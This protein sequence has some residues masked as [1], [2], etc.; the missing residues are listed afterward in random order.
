MAIELM[1]GCAGEAHIS[2]EDWTVFNQATYGDTE[3]VFDWGNQFALNM[4]SANKGTIASGAGLVDG[5]RFWIKTPEEIT[6]ETGAQGMKRNDIIGIQYGTQTTDGKT[7][8]HATVTV[9]KGTPAA[10]T[11]ADPTIPD[12]FLALYRQPLDGITLGTAVKLFDVFESAKGFRDSVSQPAK[13][14]SIG[15]GCYA[16]YKAGLVVVQVYNTTLTQGK[17]RRL[18]TLPEGM[19]PSRPVVLIIEYN[20]AS[21]HIT[22]ATTG[23]VDAFSDGA[24]GDFSGGGSFAV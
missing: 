2:S 7:T 22:I 8:E 3:L 14:T 4:T 13:W 15:G 21:G 23:T 9:L 19:R 12:H 18:G 10:D 6:I 24:S 5:K 16:A 17:T 11:A 20:G 1:D